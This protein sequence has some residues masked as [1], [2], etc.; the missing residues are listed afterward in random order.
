MTASASDRDAASSARGRGLRLLTGLI[1]AALGVDIGAVA[2]GPIAAA[3]P[4]W[5]ARVLGAMI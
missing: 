5:W 2:A 1:G 3:V 4:R